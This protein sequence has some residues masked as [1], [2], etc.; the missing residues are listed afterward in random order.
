[1]QLYTVSDAARED[2]PGT[3]LRLAQIGFK[4]VELAG[5]HGHTPSALKAAADRAG[6][7]LVSADL[8]AI[9]RDNGPS[10]TGDLARLADDLHVLGISQIVLSS[11][12]PPSRVGPVGPN[13]AFQDYRIRVAAAMREEDWKATADFLNEKSAALRIEGIALGYHNH[14]PEFAS[15]DG[16]TGFDIL[17]RETDPS[18]FFELDVGWVVAGGADPVS[19]LNRYAPR[20]RMMHVKDIAATTKTNYLLA[21]DPTE[22]GRGIVDWRRVL[23][24]AYAAGIRHFFVEQEPPFRQGRFEALADGFA[25]LSSL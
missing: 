15:V 19:L 16:T 8:P 9:A 17:M 20:I 25:Y 5:Y 2:L 23:P 24:T 18:I 13:E 1:V 22:V 3:F 21:Q 4:T 7:K 12:P 10:L 14:N 11:Y 6:L